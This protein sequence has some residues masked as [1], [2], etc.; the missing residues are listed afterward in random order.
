[1]RSRIARV[2]PTGQDVV[3]GNPAGVPDRTPLLQ[4]CRSG[5]DN[6]PMGWLRGLLIV[7]VLA[8][9]VPAAADAQVGAVAPLPG[10][11]KAGYVPLPD[12][13]K[14]KYTALLPEGKGPFPVLLQYEGYS[15]GS[16]PTRAN[17][18]FVPAMLKKG[19]AVVGVSLRGSG[20][21]TGVWDLFDKQQAKDGAFAI[22][23]MAE[24]PWANGKVAMYSYS[25]GGIMQLWVAAE[26]PKHLVAI[27]PANVVSDTYRDI[28]YPGGILNAVFPPEWGAT[29]NVDWTLGM[30]RS[31]KAGDN[32]CLGNYLA[33][34]AP[35]NLNQLAVQIPQHPYDDQWHH[36]HSSINWVKDIDVPALGVRT[37]QD[38]ETGS[39][40]ASYWDQLDPERTWLISSNGNHLVYQH[41]SVMLKTL[42]GFYD[43]FL[44]GIDNGFEKTPR[45]QVWHETGLDSDPRSITTVDRLPGTVDQADLYLGPDGRMGGPA[46]GPS[47]SASYVYPLPSP[48][49]VDTSSQG[50]QEAL[51]VSTWTVVPDL[52]A[53]RAAFTTPP[54]SNTATTY[55]PSSADLWVST[56]APDVDLQTTI[57]E[58]R[59]DG[60]EVYIQR[61]WLRASHRALDAKRSTALQPWHPHTKASTADM[62]AGKPQLL[63]VELFPSGHTFRPGSSV[64]IYVE[65]PSITGLWGY[66]SVLTPQT[67]KVHYGKDHPSRLVLGLLRDAN[68]RS[69][70]PACGALLNQACRRN[71][72]P[73]P[74]GSYALVGTRAAAPAT[75]AK[76]KLTV[77]FRGRTAR[78]GVRIDVRVQRGPAVRRVTVQL[79]RGTTVL[80]R[81]AS[82]T[83]GR[84]TRAV[85]LRRT[86]GRALAKGTYSLVVR[87]GNTVLL[88]RTVRLGR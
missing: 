79:R 38:E 68:V 29:L 1:M 27:T 75:A 9:A 50:L 52:A 18:T 31:S 5:A 32:E 21:S 44:K 72:V 41:S 2:E 88:K 78:R 77:R 43:H 74:G 66:T 36:D 61:G 54:L 70:R 8:C 3:T 69:D 37:W 42:G 14:L 4:R 23:W 56:T 76:P 11:E 55:G 34:A 28:G 59:P 17:D 39:R 45:M 46:D 20:C 19:Y 35:N 63:R 82:M 40:Q 49:V 65:Q 58:V 15:A 10:T 67:V 84:R 51:N 81:S 60:Q 12:G 71:P 26:R 87:S 22:D 85:T 7:I 13:T 24:Q 57:T 25:Y 73:Q 83:V 47:G 6:Q 16:D 62:P 64:R 53:G 30:Q 48:P 86:G 80:A 33:H